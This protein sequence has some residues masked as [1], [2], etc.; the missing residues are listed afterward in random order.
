MFETFLDSVK[1]IQISELPVYAARTFMFVHT[2]QIMYV[3][4]SA[5]VSISIN[6]FIEQIRLRTFMD[7]PA[8]FILEC[9]GAPFV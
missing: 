6:T 7:R 5:A 3:V 9:P 4:T 8:D 1:F 2:M